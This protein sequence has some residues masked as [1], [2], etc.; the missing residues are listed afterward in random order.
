MEESHEFTFHSIGARYAGGYNFHSGM[1]QQDACID[2]WSKFQ[3][4]K[5]NIFIED[6][7]GWMILGNHFS[8]STEDLAHILRCWQTLAGWNYAGS[9]GVM[10]DGSGQ[11]R[12]GMLTKGSVT[13]ADNVVNTNAPTPGQEDDIVAYRVEDGTVNYH[14]NRFVFGVG[15]S[16]ILDEV[17]TVD[18]PESKIHDNTLYQA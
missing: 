12:Y 5:H 17:V 6:A 8:W 7:P 16:V 10:G 3:Y 9:V 14:D 2:G 11:T 1:G 13:L 4:A 18:T 15:D